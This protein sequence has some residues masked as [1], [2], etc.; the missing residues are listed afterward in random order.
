MGQI[1][2]AE[3][4]KHTKSK[5]KRPHTGGTNQNRCRWGEQPPDLRPHLWEAFGFWMRPNGWSRSSEGTRS[6][7]RRVR[8]CSSNCFQKERW[9]QKEVSGPV[10]LELEQNSSS[11]T[12]GADGSPTA[13]EEPVSFQ[14]SRQWSRSALGKICKFQTQSMVRF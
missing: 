7:R 4:V 14:T 2:E 13:W 6:M 9:S 8:L 10:Q 12:P 5:C 3:R 1:H 11:L